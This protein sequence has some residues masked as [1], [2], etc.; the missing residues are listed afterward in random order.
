VHNFAVRPFVF[1]LKPVEAE[2]ANEK[3][4][5]PFVRSGK[6][7][8]REILV[9]N[10][11]L[12]SRVGL[13]QKQFTDF[14][15]RFPALRDLAIRYA[16][17][18]KLDT[19]IPAA[20]HVVSVFSQFSM[21][22][23][24]LAQ[25][26]RQ[27]DSSPESFIE[28]HRVMMMQ[29][30]S[31]L[32]SAKRWIYFCRFLRLTFVL[33][34]CQNK[35]ETYRKSVNEWINEIIK[36]FSVDSDSAFHELIQLIHDMK[37]DADRRSLTQRFPQLAAFLFREIQEDEAIVSVPS[38]L[39]HVINHPSFFSR[40]A[41]A[42]ILEVR[43]PEIFGN[44]VVA[45][46]VFKFL[47]V[48][49]ALL[50]KPEPY[51]SVILDATSPLFVSGARLAKI[52]ARR[53][54]PQ[55]QNFQ[56]LIEAVPVAGFSVEKAVSVCSH[57]F[58]ALAKASTVARK[59]D[60]QRLNV[61]STLFAANPNRKTAKYLARCLIQVSG[62]LDPCAVI[63]TQLC[64]KESGF[65]FV[66]VVAAAFFRAIPTDGKKRFAE[67]LRVIT[68]ISSEARRAALV[69]MIEGKLDEAFELAL[70]E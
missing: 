33:D 18:H 4:I 29:H 64:L 25:V 48:N 69:K 61:M 14:F 55:I 39:L 5:S 35:A 26:C 56:T 59:I 52:L 11:L 57:F 34:V 66:L 7:T 31:E 16:A 21:K 23:K 8:D 13:S 2:L 10:F 9:R 24:Y 37:P 46:Q 6:M 67:S 58:D 70:A 1:K 38:V 44:F 19:G 54:L 12:F 50:V 30:I 32:T 22:G 49:D 53:G 68:C 3:T 40:S 42:K 36:F 41:I 17:D 28:F 43:Q 45:D 62:F 65:L 60:S 47:A 27:S 15:D 63:L 51:L 20:A